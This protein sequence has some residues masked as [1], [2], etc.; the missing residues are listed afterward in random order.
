MSLGEGGGGGGDYCKV[1]YD[2]K[3]KEDRAEKMLLEE[4]EVASD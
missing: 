4:D 2:K 1:V 3:S